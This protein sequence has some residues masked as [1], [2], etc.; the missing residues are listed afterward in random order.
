MT[1][2]SVS[3]IRDA[4]RLVVKVGSALVTN[5][6]RGLDP[7]A[8][9]I[10]GAQLARLRALGKEVVMVSSGAIAEGVKRLGWP[11]RP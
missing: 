8:I 9:S 5:E 3:C 10:W 2:A 6:G 1:E 4:R 7:E 11:K